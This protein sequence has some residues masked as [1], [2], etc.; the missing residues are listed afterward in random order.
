MLFEVCL[1]FHHDISALVKSLALNPNNFE[2]T[3]IKI[4]P[5]YLYKIIKRHMNARTAKVDLAWRKV[6]SATQT[7][8]K[9]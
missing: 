5:I 9:N 8:K 1:H 2:C 6:N 7:E 4:I 3:L